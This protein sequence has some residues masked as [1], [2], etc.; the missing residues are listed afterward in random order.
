MSTILARTIDNNYIYADRSDKDGNGNNIASTYATQASVS[1]I[2]QVPAAAAADENKVLGVTDAQGSVGWVQGGGA[3]THTIVVDDANPY[4]LAPKT[5]RAQF[6]NTSYDPTNDLESWMFTCKQ[7]SSTPN[8]WDI[9]FD[10]QMRL[11]SRIS[12]DRSGGFDVLDFN[13][14]GLSSISYLFDSNYALRNLTILDASG[15]EDMEHICSYCP[16]LLSVSIAR[17]DS[18]KTLS[19]AFFYATSLQ[20]ATFGP[21]T[22]IENLDTA[23]ATTALTALPDWSD[24]SFTNLTNVTDVF[25]QCRDIQSGIQDMYTKLSGVPTITQHSGAFYQCGANGPA[26]S[27]LDNIPSSWGGNGQ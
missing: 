14:Y 16:N 13:I 25:S 9:T 3:N 7:V 17:T 1:A 10:T 19:N 23:F 4:G 15:I 12:S 6:V 20:S 22:S 24:E 11:G 21:L 26:A 27:E 18:V 5:M 8:V 2:R